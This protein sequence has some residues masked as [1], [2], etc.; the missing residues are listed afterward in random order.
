MLNFL[1]LAS[2]PILFL[3]DYFA[4]VHWLLATSP[5][6]NRPIQ[7]SMRSLLI[8][9]TISAMHCASFAAFLSAT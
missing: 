6:P 7:F 5:Q 3:A 8:A 4:M 9:M 2:V 1:A